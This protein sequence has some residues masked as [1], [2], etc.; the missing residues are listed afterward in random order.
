MTTSEINHNLTKAMKEPDSFVAQIVYFDAQGIKTRRFVSPISIAFNGLMRAT[1]LTDDKPKMF[2]T[3]MIES[4]VA[5]DANL[6][7]IPA[8][9]T[10][11]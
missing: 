10:A 5:V 6:V 1:C 2:D 8:P 9:I 4:A 3:R 7:S 11:V